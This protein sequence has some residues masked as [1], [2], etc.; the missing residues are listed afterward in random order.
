M[1]QHARTHSLSAV[2]V[3]SV[4]V[5][6]GLALVPSAAA[7]PSANSCTITGTTGDDIL[8]GTPGDD[9]I[10]GLGGD[11]VLL[12]MGG[13]DVLRGGP[14]DDQLFGGGGDDEFAGGRGD[15]RLIDTYNTKITLEFQNRLDTAITFTELPRPLYICAE[16]SF[17]H[18]PLTI[19]KGDGRSLVVTYFEFQP[20]AGLTHPEPMPS[21]FRL[22]Y[23]TESGQSGECVF[24]MN[25]QWGWSHAVECRGLRVRTDQDTW[26][27]S[28]FS[29]L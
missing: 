1:A 15:D 18:F 9:V 4:M 26:W 16:P 29:K 28:T 21:V 10:C 5:V 6:A 14:G 20:C 19:P 7:A 13:D 27:L 3:A 12:G 11:D 24:T 17:D 22:D 25:R 2:L 23:R 8:R